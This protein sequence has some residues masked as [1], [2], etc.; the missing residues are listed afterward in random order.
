M[1]TSK[2]KDLEAERVKFERGVTQLEEKTGHRFVRR[3][4]IRQALT[5]SSL[6][7]EADK[8][9][10]ERL[11]FL[12]DRVVEL[13]VSDWL[14]Q[15]R[16]WDEGEL[17]KVLSWLV[18][19]E[20]LAKAARGLGLDDSIRVGKSYAGK[21]PSAGMLADSFEA[22]IGAVFI[23]AGL[24]VASRLVVKFL[25][26]KGDFGELPEDYFSRNTLEERCRRKG[27]QVPI[28][29]HLE[30]GPEHEKEFECTVVVEGGLAGKGIG[31]TKKE[32]E[33]R[34]SADLLSRM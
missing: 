16:P 34:A 18:D 9:S 8:E 26:R 2:N 7:E 31:R 13:A 25:L 6:A 27:V 22:V 14:F 30:R 33:R 17:S 12:G 24:D 5:H 1:R 20:S 23:D 4:L 19:E 21:G 3:E 11:E 32:A 10:Y 29:F 28:Y 15:N